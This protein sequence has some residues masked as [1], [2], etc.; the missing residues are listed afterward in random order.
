VIAAAGPGG[1]PQVSVYDGGTGALISSFFAYDTGFNG[2]VYVAAGDVNGDGFA[3]IITG[4]D[5]GAGP[6]VK[7]FSGSDS[8]L[9]RSFFAYAPLFTGG[10]RVAAGDVNGDGRSDIITGVGSGAGPHVK[11]FDGVTGIEVLSF[12]AYDAAFTGGVF[13]AAGD[14]NGDGFADVVTGAGAGGNGHV[15]VFSGR[16][17]STLQSFFAF[18]GGFTGGVTVAAGDVN[19]DGRA[20]LVTGAG[21][22]NPP[23]IKVFSGSTSEV[24]SSFLAFGSGFTGG[25]FVAAGP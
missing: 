23:N 16:D 22:G 21:P 3:D 12:F 14:V 20:D 13:V 15:K 9:L 25:V 11:A 24:I 10:V 7:V 19:G 5:A 6:H 8:S 18:S 4:S 17:G 2:G 1:G